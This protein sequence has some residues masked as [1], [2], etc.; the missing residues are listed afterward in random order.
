MR[1]TSILFAAAG[2]ALAGASITP[3]T[4]SQVTN[5][6]SNP[7]NVGFYIYVP[8]NLAKSPGI[9]VAIHYCEKHI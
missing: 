7:T 9:V 4:L 5:F 2:F 3:G 8:R 1:I 6:G